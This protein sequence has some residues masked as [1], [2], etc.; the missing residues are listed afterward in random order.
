MVILLP[1][2]QIIPYDGEHILNALPEILCGIRDLLGC[3][4]S[5]L[6]DRHVKDVKEKGTDHSSEKNVG[7]VWKRLKYQK[8]ICNKTKRFHM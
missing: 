1:G 3:R 8:F 5:S 6:A 7:C 2:G 4:G